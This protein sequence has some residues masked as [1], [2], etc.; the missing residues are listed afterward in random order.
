ML[1]PVE[2]TDTF[3][4]EPGRYRATCTESRVI[5][6][7]TRKG[8]ANRLRIIWELNIPGSE[9]IR[10]LVGKS[11]EP[12]LTKDSSLRNDLRSWFG[13][14][15]NARNFDTSTLKGIKAIITVKDI[16]NEG[17]DN[18]YHSVAKIEPLVEEDCDDARLISPDVVC[19]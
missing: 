3:D 6:K 14:D 7:Q 13:H 1:I 18:P 5:Q 10:Y 9:N 15:I 16:E 12:T 2:Q 4:V 19:G 17:W 11:Y 8:S